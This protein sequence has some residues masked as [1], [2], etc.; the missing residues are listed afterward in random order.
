MKN[1]SLPVHRVFRVKK[2]N[3]RDG[4]VGNVKKNHAVPSVDITTFSLITSVSRQ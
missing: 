4:I 1:I 2:I 3:F